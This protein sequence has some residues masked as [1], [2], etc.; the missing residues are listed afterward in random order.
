MITGNPT[1]LQQAWTLTPTSDWHTNI[2]F[3]K[4]D[5]G[6]VLGVPVITAR[7]FY[8]HITLEWKY[9]TFD[10]T[11]RHQFQSFSSFIFLLL[12]LLC[13]IKLHPELCCQIIML[14]YPIFDDVFYE[15]VP[16]VKVSSFILCLQCHASWVWHTRMNI[17]LLTLLCNVM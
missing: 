4:V 8:Y 7:S 1:M 6:Y 11:F 10:N 3:T 16:T 14:K 15:S 12:T 13:S 9:P 5:C 17:F 2:E